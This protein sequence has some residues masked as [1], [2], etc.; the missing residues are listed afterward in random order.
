MMAH[1]GQ[2]VGEG[3]TPATMASVWRCLKK[4]R[5][6]LPPKTAAPL[7]DTPK[8]LYILPQRNLHIHV[9]CCSKQ[10]E[11][12]NSL[13]VRQLMG[14]ENVVRLHYRMLFSYEVK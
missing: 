5:I 12:G 6:Y 2:H 1:A 9:H 8:E 11:T 10:P 3:N 7:L 14:S 13:G 4:A